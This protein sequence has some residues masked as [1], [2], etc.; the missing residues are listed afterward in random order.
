MYN[1][2]IFLILFFIIYSK[3]LN[4][5]FSA[6][7]SNLSSPPLFPF[8]YHKVFLYVCESMFIL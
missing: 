2:Y 3:I 4:I 8:G 6:I 1:I 5:V 7:G